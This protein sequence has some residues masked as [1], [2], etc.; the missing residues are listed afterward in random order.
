MASPQP[1]KR[2]LRAHSH[3]D[4]NGIIFNFLVSSNVYITNGY[5][6]TKWKCSHVNSILQFQNCHCR[7]SEQDFSFMTW[8]TLKSNDSNL[9]FFQKLTARKHMNRNQSMV[10]SKA[11]TEQSIEP[12]IK[13]SKGSKICTSEWLKQNTTYMQE[14]SILFTSSKM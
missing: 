11:V 14:Q 8:I 10:S 1:S 13:M 12:E 3:S 6:D 7:H 4:S 5:S 9:I 2:V